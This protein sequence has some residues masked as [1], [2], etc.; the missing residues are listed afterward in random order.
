[1]LSTNCGNDVKYRRHQYLAIPYPLHCSSPLLHKCPEKVTASNC[2]TNLYVHLLKPPKTRVPIND[3]YSISWAIKLYSPDISSTRRKQTCRPPPP[4][5]TQPIPEIRAKNNRAS[6][7]A[8]PSTSRVRL[9]L[10][11]HLI[12]I[13]LRGLAFFLFRLLLLLLSPVRERRQ[14]RRRRGLLPPPHNSQ[15]SIIGTGSFA[16]QKGYETVAGTMLM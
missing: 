3:I 13:S 9:R 12:I 7:R 1:M 8:T 10:V 4:L 6:S 15:E 16:R 11:P 2:H 5:P 14:R